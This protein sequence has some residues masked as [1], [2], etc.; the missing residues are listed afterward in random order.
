MACGKPVIATRVGGLPEV[1]S[2]RRNGLLVSPGNS[3][4]LADAIQYLLAH[5]QEAQKLGM[6]GARRVAAEFSTEVVV[7]KIEG[8]YKAL[9][10][11]K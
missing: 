1:I 7:D 10:D 2:D 3:Q 9:C 6:E 5:Q 11:V 8:I 4:E